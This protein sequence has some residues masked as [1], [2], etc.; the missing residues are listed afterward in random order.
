M[1]Q[2]RTDSVKT[3][4]LPVPAVRRALKDESTNFDDNTIVDYHLLGYSSSH[5]CLQILRQGFR[6]LLAKL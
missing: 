1:M 3:A 2:Q 6:Y 5:A 4:Y